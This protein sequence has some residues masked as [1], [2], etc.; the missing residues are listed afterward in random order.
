MVAASAAERLSRQ[1]AAAA[2]APVSE[3]SHRNRH[4][5]KSSWILPPGHKEEE[6]RAAR[7]RSARRS[8]C[9]KR[10]SGSR[11]CGE[12]RRRRKRRGREAEPAVSGLKESGLRCG[13]SRATGAAGREQQDGYQPPGLRLER[14][15]WEEA[16]RGKRG[17]SETGAN[18]EDKH[19]RTPG[20]RF[21]RIQTIRLHSAFKS[22]K[23]FG[24]DL[25]LHFL[26]PAAPPI[27]PL[28]FPLLF[29]NGA[30]PLFPLSRHLALLASQLLTRIL[31]GIYPS[32]TRR[33]D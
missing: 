22:W 32:P 21:C 3:G 15:G 25:D 2:A 27:S 29:R 20:S 23:D 13:Q 8:S 28:T 4:S 7:L 19:P 30:R 18:P 9:V 10:C 1:E 17:F 16:R 14:C 33:V 5:A 6:G 11:G 24:S 12:R 31:R 26:F